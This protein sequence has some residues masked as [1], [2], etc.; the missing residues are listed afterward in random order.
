MSKNAVISSMGHG[1]SSVMS[2]PS[3][4][5]EYQANGEQSAIT[6]GQTE[7]VVEKQSVVAEQSNSDKVSTA[8]ATVAK[9]SQS[10]ESVD[11]M[12][13]EVYDAIEKAESDFYCNK[14]A[15]DGNQYCADEMAG[16]VLCANIPKTLKGKDEDF[17]NGD[18]LTEYI[19]RVFRTKP[20][21]LDGIKGVSNPAV[22]KILKAMG[23]TIA[24][25]RATRE[26]EIQGMPDAIFPPENQ[27]KLLPIVI[28]DIFI[29]G[30]KKAGKGTISDCLDVIANQN[31]YNPVWDMILDTQYD[32]VDR[33][34]CLYEILGIT[35]KDCDSI[36]VLHRKERSRKLLTKWLVQCVAMAFNPSKNPCTGE[37]I[38]VLQGKQGLGKTLFFRVLGVD[39]EWFGEGK[40]VDMNKKDSIIQATGRWITE[41]GEVDSTL[42]KEQSSLKAFITSATDNYRAAYARTAVKMPRRTSFCA[43]V[44]PHQFLRDVTGSR[45]FWVIH[46]D[47]IDVD[48][49]LQLDREWLYQLWAQVYNTLY[50]PNPQ[51]FRLTRE[52]L[53]QLEEDNQEFYVPVS[54]EI[55]I[56]DKLCWELPV[57]EWEYV[58]VSDL[59]KRV[60]G[61][62]SIQAGKLLAKLSEHDSRIK[63]KTVHNKKRYLLPPMNRSE[64]QFTSVPGESKI[65]AMVS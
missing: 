61:M 60:G 49:L 22:S 63:L 28:R 57:E 50:L 58:L 20:Q 34:S 18:Q 46:V 25:N 52:E 30:G 11:F 12:N 31:S 54:G 51:G 45:R 3:V 8:A 15:T 38:L 5:A 43:T 2:L 13:S 24:Y 32:G 42:V 62:N 64:A 44:N 16:D 41:L 48:A 21:L 7:Q 40:T 53:R 23:I 55:D 29:E 14:D 1:Q 39:P 27:V 59:A 35:G 47:A 10:M 17:Q 26:L 65:K 36:E 19:N 33:I 6:V 4:K 56:M 37:G 9:A